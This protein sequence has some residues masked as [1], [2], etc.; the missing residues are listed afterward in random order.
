[1]SCSTRS[2]QM[3]REPASAITTR[4]AAAC[5]LTCCRRSGEVHA[6]ASKCQLPHS[7][8]RRGRRHD[9]RSSLLDHAERPQDHDVSGRGRA[10]LQDFPGEHR[11]GRPVQ[12]GISGDRAEQPHPGDD[13]S[14]AER[15]RQADLDFRIRR[16]AAVSG[17]EDRQIP[18]CRSAWPLRRDPVDVLADGRA[19]PD[20]RTEPSLLAIT[21]RTRSNTPST[22][23]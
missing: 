18:A 17:R 1:M 14:R 2:A 11:Q 15:R 12:A 7:F 10:P 19:R 6:N 16:D 22:A 21:R 13:R 3:N 23:M 20:G 8:N 5:S 9:D 4:C